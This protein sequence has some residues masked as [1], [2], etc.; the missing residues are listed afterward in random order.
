MDKVGMTGTRAQLYN[1]LALLFT[2]FTSRLVF[3]TYQSYRVLYDM[4]RAMGES[5]SPEAI[6]LASMLYVNDDTTVPT[7]ALLSYVASNTTL[8]FLNFMWFYKMVRAVRKRFEP[9]QE[10]V[11]EVEVDVSTVVSG[12]DAKK[13]VHRRRP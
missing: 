6:H 11:T 1:G 2:F 9:G 5:P 12:I 13:Q 4:W 7:W 3:G 10:S 8:N